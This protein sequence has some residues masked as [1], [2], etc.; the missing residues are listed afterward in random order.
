MMVLALV[1][2]T[3]QPARPDYDAGQRAWDDARPDEALTQWRAAANEGDRRAMLALGRL[4]LRGLGVLQDYIEAHKWFNLAAG[5]GEAAALKERDA[6]AAKMTPEQMA[7]AQERAAAWRPGAGRAD[8][9]PDAADE[10]ATAAATTQA[11]TAGEGPPPPRAIRAAQALL[12]ALGYRPGPADGIW[13]RRTGEAYRAFL[14]D[15]GLPVAETLTPQALLAM[16]AMVKRR[17]GAAEEGRGAPASRDSAPAAPGASVARPAEA[18]PDA[19]HRAAQAGDVDGLKMALAAGVDMDARDGR[20]WTALMHAVNKGYTLLVEP[21]LEAQ[22]AVDVRAPDGATALFMA[23]AYGHTEIVA[24]LMKAGADISIRGLKGKTAGDV[25]R[26]QYGEPD[27]AREKGV[28]AAVLALLEGKMWAEVER[29]RLAREQAEARKQEEREQER[30]Q[31]RERLYREY[32]ERDRPLIEA[33]QTSEKRPG[34]RFKDCVGCPELVVVPAGSYQ[35]GSPSGKQGRLDSEGPV[36]RVTIAQPLAVGVYEVTFDEWDAC[37]SGGGCNGYRPG[38][39]GWGRGRRPVISLN[40][41]DAKLYVEWLS[42]ETGEG[43]RLLSESEWEYVARAGTTTP[44]HFGATISTEQANYNGNYT[45]GSGRNGEYREKT[46]PVGSFPP[47][48]YGLHDVHGNVWEW[49]EDCRHD[50]Y[51]GAPSDGSA[52]TRGEGCSKR[53]VRGGSWDFTPWS[54]RSAYRGRHSTANRS[55]DVGFRVARTLTP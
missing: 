46:V 40:W 8:G 41:E 12:R 24:L 9:T 55:V 23:A 19:L 30:E 37:V 18:R 38:D 50:S 35:M 42:R 51:R 32:A 14:R 53:V 17:A 36:H 4:Y 1:L 2:A 16:R 26:M 45:Y 15:A 7:T 44:F 11:S 48:A 39:G 33:G 27:A 22:A 49:V 3:T 29:E 20:G 54:L 13:G 25:A 28:D 34:L 21:L 47:N 43:Y 31:E 5:R 6:L 52:W 10:R